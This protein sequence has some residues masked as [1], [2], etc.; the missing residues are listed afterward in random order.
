M[1]RASAAPRMGGLLTTHR[2]F[3]NHSEM[4]I[5]ARFSRDRSASLL[6]LKSR[7]AARKQQLMASCGEVSPPEATLGVHEA[8]AVA[9]AALHC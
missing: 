1:G 9:A 4:A 6:I 2:E 5:F 3:L 8:V 7:I